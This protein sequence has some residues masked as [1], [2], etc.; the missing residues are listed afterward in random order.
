MNASKAWLVRAVASCGYLSYLPT[1][2]FPNKGMQTGAGFIGS[3]VGLATIRLLPQISLDCVTVLAGAFLFSV[4]I[5]DVAEHV[6]RR[7]DDPRIVIDEWVGYWCAIAF[8]PRTWPLLIG[9]FILFRFFDVKKPLGIHKAAQCPGG[10]GI[11][12]DDVAAGLIV[13]VI[14]HL[15]VASRALLS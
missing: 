12:L 4:A 9:G 3:L 10:W 14:L 1:L 11:V 7:K 2:F 13:N 5:A 8:L 15:A 6:M